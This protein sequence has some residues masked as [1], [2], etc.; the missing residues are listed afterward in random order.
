MSVQINRHKYIISFMTSLDDAKRAILRKL[1][2]TKIIRKTLL[3]LTQKI[4]KKAN[5][6]IA[7]YVLHI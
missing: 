6:Y 5:I 2:S 7:L 4:G 3:T 1:R